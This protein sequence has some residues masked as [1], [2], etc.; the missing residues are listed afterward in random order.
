[1]E[2]IIN[3]TIQ[4]RILHR[5]LLEAERI[6]KVGLLN[7]KMGIVLFFEHYYKHTRQAIYDTAANDLMENILQCTHQELSLGFSDGLCGIGWGVEYLLQNELA[8]GNSAEICE[9][10]DN[11]MMNRSPRRM[12]D[13][14][15]TTGLEGLLHYV[16]AHISGAMKQNQVLPFDEVYLKELFDKIKAI[17]H[18]KATPS[19]KNLANLY[20]DFYQQRNNSNYLMT[21]KPFIDKV[22]IEEKKLL[23]YPITLKNGLASYMLNQILS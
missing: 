1:M 9:E 2:T 4:Q 7:G 10:I 12:T 8:E 20:T 21:L 23:S 3:F 18:K 19:F 16:L 5:L 11:S 17:D 14:S 15:L 13:L 6:K 22:S